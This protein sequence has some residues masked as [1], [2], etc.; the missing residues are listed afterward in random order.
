MFKTPLKNKQEVLNVT[1]LSKISKQFI[2]IFA[3]LKSKTTVI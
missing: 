1:T 2:V 3:K